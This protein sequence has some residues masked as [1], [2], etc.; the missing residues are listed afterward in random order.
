MKQQTHTITR[1]HSIL[2]MAICSSLWSIGGLFIKMIPWNS[3]VITSFRSLITCFVFFAYMKF[4]HYK[5]IVSKR[6]ILAGC[7]LCAA[8]LCYVA[9]N[10]LTTAAN[11]IMIQYTFPVFI[12]LVSCIIFHQR[13][14]LKDIA[15]VCIAIFGI[16]LFF[17]DDLNPGNM[18]GN[19]I[20]L[21]A[22]IALG[23]FFMF[24]NRTTSIDENMS[25]ILMGNVISFLA[26]VPFYFLEPPVFTVEATISVF[27]L[28]IFQLGVPYILYGIAIRNCPPLTASLI[29][30][31]EP[32]LNPVW[33]ALVVGEIPGTLAIIGG[34]IV[35]VTVTAYSISN[36]KS[37]QKEVTNS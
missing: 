29:S 22:G 16:L 2:L 8:F 4:M 36:T 1:Q 32:L 14:R 31:F 27:V 30:M 35:V 10:K 6:T 5:I 18:A 17:L 28:G 37:A 34:I 7:A 21:G 24:G 19:F 13:P 26:G 33:V 20:A 11:A 15:V 25:A 9:A 23:T 3:F 12:L